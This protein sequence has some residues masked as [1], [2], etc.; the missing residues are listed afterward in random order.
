MPLALS[1]AGEP[2]KKINPLHQKAVHSSEKR[3][4]LPLNQNRPGFQQKVKIYNLEAEH[5]MLQ[6]FL[7]VH[8]SCSDLGSLCSQGQMCVEEGMGAASRWGEEPSSCWSSRGTTPQ[9]PAPR[10]RGLQ[11]HLGKAPRG[12][13]RWGRSRSPSLPPAVTAPARKN[14]LCKNSQAFQEHMPEWVGN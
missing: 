12:S 2:Y 9:P 8:P 10:C 5:G 4:L 6:D 14:L 1:R 7:S 3:Q 11:P 13:P